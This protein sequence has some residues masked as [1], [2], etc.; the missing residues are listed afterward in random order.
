ML[1]HN[2]EAE[3]VKEKQQLGSVFEGVASVER[4]KHSNAFV[5]SLTNFDHFV[6]NILFFSNKSFCRFVST[7]YESVLAFTSC[8]S[9]C[10][11]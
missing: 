11:C 5:V 6:N 3:R 10:Q 2:D 8:A 4:A 7:T 9:W 1:I